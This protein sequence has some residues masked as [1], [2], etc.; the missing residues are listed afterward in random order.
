M[1]LLAALL[2]V[3]AFHTVSIFHELDIQITVIMKTDLEMVRRLVHYYGYVRIWKS[4]CTV[5]VMGVVIPLMPP[6][7]DASWGKGSD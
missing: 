2:Q 4:L 3:Q 1:Y 6:V 7:Y 5:L